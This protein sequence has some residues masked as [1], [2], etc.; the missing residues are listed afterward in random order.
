MDKKTYALLKLMEK[1]PAM[2]LSE[3]TL[4][5][6]DS[7]LMGYSCAIREYKIK[8]NFG[9]TFDFMEWTANKL[10]YFESTAGWANMILASTIGLNP[11][12]IRWENYN[13]NVT[14]EQHQ[15]SVKKFYELIDEYITEIK[16]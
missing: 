13:T 12:E 16:N 7:F 8:E 11:K 10:G 9:I 1:R 3:V 5:S 4:K 14:K 6:Y 15:N 2:W